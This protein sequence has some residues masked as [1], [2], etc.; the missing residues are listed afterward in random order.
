MAEV[1]HEVKPEGITEEVPQFIPTVYLEVSKE[2]L[3]ML[4]VGNDVVMT[5]KGKVKGLQ[6]RDEG[7]LGG[8]HEIQLEL[9]EV[10]IDP[11]DNDFSKLLDEDEK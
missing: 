5:L 4:E 6:A 2:Q 7:E 8:R 3:E 9:Q 11:K 10:V 1:K